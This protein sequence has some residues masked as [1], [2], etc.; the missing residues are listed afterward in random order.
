MEAIWRVCLPQ[1]DIEKHLLSGGYTIEIR[2]GVYVLASL[3]FR[4]F[5]SI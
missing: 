2:S 5:R 3:D 4:S 1:M